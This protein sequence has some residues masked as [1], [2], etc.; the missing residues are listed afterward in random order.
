ME[1]KLDY[2]TI[3][4]RAK[5]KSKKNRRNAG[6]VQVFNGTSGVMP[7]WQPIPVPDG[8]IYSICRTY[9]VPGSAS[10]TFA[11]STTL[12]T[13]VAYNFKL[14]DVND[15]ADLIKVFDDFRIRQVEVWITP[16]TMAAGGAGQLVSVVDYNDDATIST[17]AIAMNHNNAQV[18]NV[19]M[20]HYRKFAPAAAI[21]AYDGSIFGG[22]STV[23]SPW[24]AVA[25][26]TVEHYGL[27]INTDVTLGS[28]GFWVD[29]RL[30]LDFRRSN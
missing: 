11:S 28:Y 30:L 23:T 1:T 4:R 25:S 6:V 7:H 20:G 24:L 13:K 19:I 10:Y 8:Q 2:V 14:S 21:G 27:K 16:Q 5:P 9:R 17:V 29:V 18:S 12:E 26:N 3:H 22:F 15:Y